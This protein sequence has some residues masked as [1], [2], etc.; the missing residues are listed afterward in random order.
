MGFGIKTKL[1]RTYK[2]YLVK[3]NEKNEEKKI[4]EFIASNSIKPLS[5]KQMKEIHSFW[6]STGSEISVNWHRI[7]YSITGKQDVRF[8]PDTFFHNTISPRMNNYSF[9]CIWGD[10]NYIDLFVRDAKTVESVV[11]CVN[12]RFLDREFKLITLAEAQTI[13]NRYDKLVIKP[14]TFTNTG[15]GVKLLTKP[16]NLEELAKEY[17]KNYVIQIPLIQHE[18]MSRLN[19]SSINSIRINS[20]LF[21]TE[22]HVMSSFVKVGETGQFADNNG[23]NRFF[24]G[25]T[26]DGRYQNYAIN[27]DLK[28]FHEIPS[29]FEFAGEKVPF[30]EEAYRA[31]EKAHKNIA[32]FGFA[33]WDVCISQS[34]E[35]VMIEVNLCHPDTLIGQATGRP[36]MGNYTEQILKYIKLS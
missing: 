30:I 1:I 35:P 28:V 16:F 17:K 4:D 23:K 33:F 26:E 34:G 31:V 22:A 10:K 7:L 25:I 9:S 36:F 24:I 27:H 12:G 5:E 21:D 14:A 2:E 6:N 20:V 18:D 11:R 32:H 29:G 8:V 13:M 15:K 3:K 19:P